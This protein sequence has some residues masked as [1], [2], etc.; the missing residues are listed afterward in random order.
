MTP[1]NTTSDAPGF[2]PR[3]RT[4]LL[5]V[6]LVVLILPLASIYFLRI[7]E[8][9]LVRQTENALLAQGAV[10]AA[11]YAQRIK[12][13]LADL[14]HAAQ[15]SYGLTPQFVP[16]PSDEP[17][18]FIPPPLSL[19]SHRIH[20]PRPDPG[21]GA[22]LANPI[23]LDV[24]EAMTPIIRE[25]Q[26]TTLA[27]VRVTDFHGVVVASSRAEV[28]ESL[29]TV[30]E[31]GHALKGRPVSFLR[32]RILDMDVPPLAS[33]SRGTR[34]R[35][36]MALPIFVNQRVVGVVLLSRTPKSMLKALYAQRAYV[37]AA[38]VGLLSI[39][40]A[41]ALFTSFF[42]TR[43]I[44]ALGKAAKAI[45]QG[46]RD[47]SVP[48]EGSMALEIDELGDTFQ[49]MADSV[50]FRTNYIRDFAMHV[51]HEFKTPLASL[52][53]A[54]E[55]LT[56]HLDEMSEE[57]RRRFLGNIAQDTDRLSR[58]VARLLEMAR[59]DVYEPTNEVAD[60]VA[61]SKR[62][63][64]RLQ[65]ENYHIELY[66]EETSLLVNAASVVVETVLVNLLE[67]S[68][69]HGAK[70][71]HVHIKRHDGGAVVTVKDDGHGVSSGNTDK[72][73]T[74]FF[75]TRR[76]SGGAGLGLSI[77]SSL[78]KAH[79]GDI[80]LSAPARGERGAVFI[81]T[82]PTSVEQPG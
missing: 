3:L 30:P 37:F 69:Q 10:L 20:P 78:L 45:A 62:I 15:S 75:T 72:V 16:P 44:R 49:R 41:L 21:K 11:D 48:R 57:Q 1:S 82:L 56:E 47:V 14:P 63:Q 74:P 53:G 33:L 9:E 25:A 17:F 27:G 68:R 7:Y 8:N 36:F 26:L 64:E 32:E 39:A 23:A 54:I 2:R 58:L 46:D 35:V 6:N 22:P 24:G 18:R 81:V 31:V 34:I 77:V 61:A 52:Q 13:R 42:I 59:A 80:Q 65:D 40:T 71:S 43:P 19:S 51:S 12:T 50:D 38:L 4:I 5:V 60:I 70:T 66:C 79:Q 29:L 76:K 73:F 67:N 28:G 55:L